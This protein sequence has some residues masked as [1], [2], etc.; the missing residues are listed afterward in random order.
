MEHRKTQ[1]LLQFIE[2][3]FPYNQS[4]PDIIGE[5]CTIVMLF[6][7]DQ[8]PSWGGGGRWGVRNTWHPKPQIC[9]S[10]RREIEQWRGRSTSGM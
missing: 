8:M 9:D 3:S 4:L 1:P 2:K 6:L 10:L 7:L 5:Y